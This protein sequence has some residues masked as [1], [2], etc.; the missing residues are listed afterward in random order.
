MG[1]MRRLETERSFSVRSTD[2]FGFVPR[3]S[4]NFAEILAEKACVSLF[5]S[6]KKQRK[7]EK[8]IAFTR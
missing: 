5:S 2:E 7:N 6:K 4:V 1:S 3:E 8:N